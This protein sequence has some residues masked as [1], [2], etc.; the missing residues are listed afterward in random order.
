MLNGIFQP[1]KKVLDL[2]QMRKSNWVN[3]SLQAVLIVCLSTLVSYSQNFNRP[4]PNGLP[5]Y[6]F[7]RYDTTDLNSYY[8]SAPYLHNG[9]SSSYTSMML[10]DQD[11]YLVWWTGSNKKFFD[12]KYHPNHNVLSYTQRNGATMWHYVM[13]T[14]FEVIDS[15]TAPQGYGDVHEF[16]IFPNGN[17]CFLGVTD[18]VVDL[19]NMMFNGSPGSA[20][21]H[22]NNL[23]IWEFTSNH[24]LVMRWSSAEHIPA[25]AF[26]D[27]YNY[28]PNAFDYLHGNAIELD[29]DGNLLVSMRTANAIYKVNHT[30]GSI[31]W[32]LGGNYNEFTFLNDSGFIG[33][34]DVRRTANGNITLFD[35]QIGTASGSRCLE[36]ELDH[37]DSTAFLVNEYSYNWP[38]NCFSLGSYR[39]LDNGYQI[40]GWGNT[41]RPEPS[42]TLLDSD[43]NIAADVFFKDTVVTYRAF[44]EAFESAVGQPEISCFNDGTT[45][46]L[47]APQG[48]QYY[49]WSTGEN[50]QTIAAPNSGEYLVWVNQ[51]I[52]SLGSKPLQISDPSTHC[53]TVG[54]TD[55]KPENSNIESLGY[56]DLTGRKLQAIQRGTIYLERFSSGK[57]IKHITWE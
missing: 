56:F 37:N 36:Y 22:L 30:T 14:S 45:L 47:S 48:Y 31:M 38:L 39:Q 23:I 44:F 53:L 19:S 2:K 29:T 34:H 6:E 40:I 35:N 43:Q 16:Q 55:Q 9:G 17:Y 5:E 18:T 33:Q 12:F 24:D 4:V 13:N 26:I 3:P 20:T 25:D 8:L 15:I 52:G 10:M 57:C 32:R 41:N 7:Q 49:L 51:G 42:F 46:W 27:F 1:L 54:F 21:T 11:G 50:T 28:N